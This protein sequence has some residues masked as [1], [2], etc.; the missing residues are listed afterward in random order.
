MRDFEDLSD[1]EKMLR[2]LVYCIDTRDTCWQGEAFMCYQS[3][4]AKELMEK[5]GIPGEITRELNS[6][7]IIREKRERIA[8]KLGRHLTSIPSNRTFDSEGRYCP[9]CDCATLVYENTKSCIACEGIT[10]EDYEECHGEE[11]GSRG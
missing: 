9:K 6:E 7:R 8:E 5:L 3:G 10:Y 11:N 4:K 2:T 1:V